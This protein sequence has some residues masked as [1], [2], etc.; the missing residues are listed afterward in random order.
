M[1]SMYLASSKVGNFMTSRV[2]SM[3]GRRPGGIETTKK[4]SPTPSRGAARSQLPS[5][6]PEHFVLRVRVYLMEYL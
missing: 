3:P 2:P 6:A 1:A 5:A 4:R